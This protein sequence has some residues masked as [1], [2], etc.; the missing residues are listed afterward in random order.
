MERSKQRLSNKEDTFRGTLA[1]GNNR[2][3]SRREQANTLALVCGGI[4]R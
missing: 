1:R 2:L 4:H 3:L